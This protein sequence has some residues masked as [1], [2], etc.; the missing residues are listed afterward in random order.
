M[1]SQLRNIIMGISTAGM[2]LLLWNY[3][4]GY[5]ASIA[6]SVTTTA[7][8]VTF[9]AATFDQ[10]I[11]QHQIMGEKV[12][13]SERYTA[14]EISQD[15]FKDL[16][17]L[18]LIWVGVCL[19]LS[20]STSYSRFTFFGI[21]A[22][23][24][25]F[26]NR[27]NLHEIGF[28]GIEARWVL[29]IPFAAYALPLLYFHEY[30]KSTHLLVRFGTFIAVS[31]LLLFGVQ[32]D[33]VFT[34]H[35]IAHS[36]FG[37]SILSLVFVFLVAEELIFLFLFVVT[38]NKGGGQ[39]HVHFTLLSLIYLGN[40]TLYYLNKSGLYE[41]AFFFFDPF[42]LLALSAFIAFWSIRFKEQYFST[43]IPSILLVPSV[44]V[45]GLV[46]A[47]FLSLSMSRGVDAVPQAF[48][49]FILYAHL[50]MGALFF[51]Y[52][53][54]NFLDPLIKGFEI[55]KIAFRERN[56]PYVTAKLGG[57]VAVLAFFFLSGQEGYNLLR[58]GYYNYLGTKE[59]N[60]GNSTLGKEYLINAGFLG[61]NTHY[62]N[63]LLA[64]EEWSKGNDL[65]AQ[66]NFYNASQRFPSAYAW[67]N[68][69]NLAAQENP[70]KVQALYEEA[71]RKI[72]SQEMENNLGL[73]YAG[74]G[75]F[76][77]ALDYFENSKASENWN[78]APLIN[79]WQVVYQQ[80]I[81]LD[82][83][84]KAQLKDD[85]E[86]GNFGAKANILASAKD[87]AFDFVIDEFADAPPLHRQ[88]YLINAAYALSHDSIPNFLRREI[89]L[90]AN[91]ST[92]NM[93]EMALA[94]FLY[95]SGEVNQSFRLLD[96]LQANANSYYKGKY[97]DALG[98]L[99][100]DQ[101]APRLAEDFFTAAISARYEQSRYSRLE[102]Y[103]IQG[104]MDVVTSEM[105]KIL[106][107]QPELTNQLNDLLQRMDEMRF[108][109]PQDESSSLAELEASAV[110]ELG[111]QNAFKEDLVSQAAASLSERD[112]VLMSYQILVDAVEINPYSVVLLKSYI[113]SA[114]RL[115]FDDYAAHS[116][117]QLRSLIESAEFSK[118]EMS[119]VQLREEVKSD[120]W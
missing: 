89:A 100:L 78:D 62:P 37:F 113:R 11:M 96:G 33:A 2:I 60:A 77:K 58:S 6:W 14:G 84:R 27:L 83:T 114:I 17:Y 81:L 7:K 120:V 115:G 26:I 47:G 5:S 69:G 73:I 90:S 75:D 86:L 18:S 1:N 20:F 61:Y 23:L 52:I 57:L 91:R 101:E 74:K 66:S 51:L 8:T 102:A 3:R 30:R 21:L 35:F 112:S 56:F 99:A 43:L 19:F 64:W 65:R 9:P 46:T 104:K 63:Y 13:L 88:A 36:L 54:A 42:I 116:L 12:L 29:I 70:S 98:K 107:V 4:Q 38:S 45:L 80:G 32:N 16:F 103:A 48:H 39:N 71:L 118:F 108:V 93:L 111:R 97:L 117:E 44:A 119:L 87:S 24:A 79:K 76:E 72:Q 68:Y 94:L 67:I 31:V 85:F 25:L 92:T 10:G 105:L 49:Y 22:A 50:G 59:Q 55:Y 82:S 53:I 110:Y 40:L 41:N 106:S 34:D 15:S 109:T 95:K 28:F